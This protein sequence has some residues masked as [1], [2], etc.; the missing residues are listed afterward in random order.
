M[1][2]P[3]WFL[4]LIMISLLAGCSGSSD[5]AST[6]TNLPAAN[7]KSVTESAQDYLMDPVR[8]KKQAV[9]ELDEALAKRDHDLSKQLDEVSNR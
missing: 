3:L 4:A 8:Q 7:E 2:T 5:S 9:K 1:K 6:D